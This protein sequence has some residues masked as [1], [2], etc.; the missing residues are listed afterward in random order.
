MIVTHQ[1]K[2]HPHQ[3][4]ALTAPNLNKKRFLRSDASK[5][6]SEIFFLAM[7]LNRLLQ[8][9]LSELIFIIFYFKPFF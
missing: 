5:W 1:K 3:K 6:L 9:R 4:S 8:N 7:S 2:T